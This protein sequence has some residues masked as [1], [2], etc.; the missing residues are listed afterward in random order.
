[1]GSDQH[2][3]EEVPKRQEDVTAFRMDAHAV[4][5]K[6]FAEFVEVTSYVTSCERPLDRSE[7]P[8]M[9]DFFCQPGSFV[10]RMTPHPVRLTDPRQ[11]WALVPGASWRHPEG[12]G[13]SLAGREDHP[14]VH[15]SYEDALAFARWV[16]KSIPTE[17]QWE[18]AATL[19]VSVVPDDSTHLNIWRGEFPYLN[20]RVKAH[21]FTVPAASNWRSCDGLSHMLGNV[22]EWTRSPYE[23]TPK[24]GSD[25]CTATDSRAASVQTVRALKGGSYLCADSY[26]R[27]YRPSARIG[28]PQNES[29]GHIGFRCVV[30]LPQAE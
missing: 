24:K 20:E 15:V 14:V 10:F 27:R 6:C 9:P 4:T 5:N 7:H 21:P 3:P 23:A 25:C 13:S 17:E 28:M 22:W 2:Y 16:G 26:C 11:W 8:D 18:Y 29:A 30:N 19:T 12:P 1:M